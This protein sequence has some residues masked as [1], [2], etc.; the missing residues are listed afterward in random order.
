MIAGVLWLLAAF[1][2]VVFVFG[3]GVPLPIF[4]SLLNF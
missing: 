4:G 1:C 3:L 2:V